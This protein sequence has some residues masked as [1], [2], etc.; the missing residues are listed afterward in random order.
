M[1]GWES[2]CRVGG[3][4]RLGSW[5]RHHMRTLLLLSLGDLLRGQDSSEMTY[6]RMKHL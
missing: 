4:G 6:E 1:S 5:K 2:A 3:S